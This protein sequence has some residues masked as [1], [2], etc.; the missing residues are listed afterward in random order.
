M[1]SHRI[2]SFLVAEN[3]RVEI[4]HES[5]PYF[6]GEPV[7]LVVRIRHLGSQDELFTIGDTIKTLQ[8]EVESESRERGAG[9]GSQDGG[10]QENKPWLMKSLLKAL[11]V[12]KDGDDLKEKELERKH[13]MIDTLKEQ[14]KLH[15]PIELI[16]GY[17][18]I[19]GVFQFD[20][21]FIREFKL[22]N[23]S[24]VGGGMDA[25]LQ[26][27]G[28]SNTDTVDGGSS[29]A[30]Y[31]NSKHHAL[32]DDPSSL[33]G[34]GN[35]FLAGVNSNY[36]TEYKKSPILLVP[37]TLLFTELTLE[38]GTIKTFRLKTEDL[39][40]DLPPTYNISKNVSINYNLDFG[41]GKLLLADVKE[42]KIHV[43]IFVAPYVSPM[44]CQYTYKLNQKVKILEPAIVKEIKQ[45]PNS[46][47]RLSSSF[48]ATPRRMSSSMLYHEKNDSAEKLKRNFVQLIKSNQN[49]ER[50][51][52]ELVDLQMKMQFESLDEEPFPN[53][54]NDLPHSNETSYL[55]QRPNSVA[56]NILNLR[57]WNFNT[58][59]ENSD[60]LEDSSIGLVPQISNPQNIYQ[61]NWNGQSITKLILSNTFYTTADD[62]DLVLEIDQSSPPLHK[63]SAVT[64]SLEAFELVNQNYAAESIKTSKPKGNQFYEARCICFDKCDSIPM[65]LIIPKTPM[66][67]LPSQF[68][69]DI[70][71]FKWML[72]LKFVLVPRIEN[73]NLEQFYED[74]KGVLF[75][76]KETLEGEEF[77]CHIPIPLLPSSRNFGGW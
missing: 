17:L 54:A 60:G 8:Q 48:I 68:R 36:S 65:K 47:K 75:H 4:V 61:I 70:F 24:M 52:E 38:P 34:E 43:P 35:L 18:Q 33:F 46:Q 7:S 20:A 72:V 11:N 23:T 27:G 53:E 42:Y 1:H 71:Q 14:L 67:Q 76:A 21:E 40:M 28:D 6:A 10:N 44:G 56:N 31:L 12:D 49:G 74:K 57:N 15:E 2:D 13:K 26:H 16:S 69:T 62:I 45:K 58:V 41:V 66:S 29:L 25:F 32:Q 37:Q 22:D 19:Y 9:N 5:N 51:I 3:V 50:D 63:L 39:P 30:K 55:S 64:V 73:V 59:T 77:S